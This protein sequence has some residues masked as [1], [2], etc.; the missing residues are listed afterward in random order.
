MHTDYGKSNPSGR[1]SRY[2][3]AVA[4]R[5]EKLSYEAIAK[6]R[7][8]TK[9]PIDTEALAQEQADYRRRFRGQP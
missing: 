9:K 1:A 8:R 6:G 4:Q 5:T 7:R 2:A 3:D